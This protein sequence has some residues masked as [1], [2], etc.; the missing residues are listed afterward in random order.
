[1]KIKLLNCGE[2]GNY[3]NIFPKK[4]EDGNSGGKQDKQ[5][6]S[7]EIIILDDGCKPESYGECNDFEF[8][9]HH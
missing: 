2:I 8:T 6:E 5:Q 3:T 4:N 7:M 9:N 1:M